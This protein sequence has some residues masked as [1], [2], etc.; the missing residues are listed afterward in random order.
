MTLYDGPLGKVFGGTDDDLVFTPANT[1]YP[2]VMKPTLANTMSVTMRASVVEATYISSS[3]QENEF[4][5]FIK[6][7][8][9]G[10][11]CVP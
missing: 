1:T 8:M 10:A 7:E 5:D 3:K 9:I 11:E 2:Q 6:E 4:L